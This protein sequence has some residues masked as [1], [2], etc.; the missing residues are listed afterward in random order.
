MTW[1]TVEIADVGR[2]LLGSWPGTITAWGRDAFE[3]YLHVLQA[4]G[5]TADEVLRAIGTWPAGT[6]FP[7]SAPNLAAAARKDPSAPTF[8]EMCQLVFEAGGVLRAVGVHDFDRR[9]RERLRDEAQWARAATMHPL[10]GAFVRSYGL[11]RL[12]GLDLTD[13]AFGAARRHQLHEAW[14]AFCEAH[15]SREVAAIAGGRRAEGLARLD[16]LTA[17]GKGFPYAPKQLGSGGGA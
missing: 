2:S 10:V 11:D 16:P 6:D 13:P 5:L 1:T 12:R 17:L 14:D 8:E 7:P 9:L 4:R 15:E 3:A